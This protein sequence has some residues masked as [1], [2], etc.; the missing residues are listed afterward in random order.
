VK[1]LQAEGWPIYYYYVEDNQEE[2]ETWKLQLYPTILVIRRDGERSE[3]L[4]RKEGRLDRDG[5]IEF[6]RSNGVKPPE[7][8]GAEPERISWDSKS[9]L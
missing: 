9:Y 4:G 5:L 7:V 8:P 1:R 6:M 2:A 3:E